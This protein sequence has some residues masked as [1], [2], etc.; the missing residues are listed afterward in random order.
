[1]DRKGS[2]NGHKQVSLLQTLNKTYAERLDTG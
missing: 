2:N 1:M